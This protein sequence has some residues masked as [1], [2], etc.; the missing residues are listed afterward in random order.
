[1][2]TS[3]NA[4]CLLD[5]E[6]QV[7]SGCGRHIDEIAATGRQTKPIVRYKTYLICSEDTNDMYSGITRRSSLRRALLEE[8]HNA[9]KLN[10]EGVLYDY[11][12]KYED[13]KIIPGHDNLTYEEAVAKQKEFISLYGEYLINKQ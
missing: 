11:L 10:K 8:Q 3:C 9:S 7:C 13:F 1:M 5:K 4:D 6:T 2:K 12:R